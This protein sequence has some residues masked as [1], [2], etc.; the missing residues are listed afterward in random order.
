MSTN[1]E[2]N[3]PTNISSNSSTSAFPV[4][5]I[6]ASAG[7]LEAFT[8]L[9]G[10]LAVD[11][12]M[13]FV[14]IQH[15]NPEQP[16]LLSE[17]LSR[18]TSMTVTEVQN[19]M[20][21]EP[22]CVYVIPSNRKMSIASGVLTLSQRQ[23]NGVKFMPIDSFFSALAEDVGS[24]AIGVVLSGTDGD[25]ALGLKAIKAYGGLAFAQ[26]EASSQFPGMPHSAAAT[27]LVDFIL[28]P[29]AIAAE[30]ARIV[31][32]PYLRPTITQEEIPESEEARLAVVSMLYSATGVD[33]SQYKRPSFRRR[34]QRRMA[35]LQLEQIQEYVSYLEGHP[36][37]VQA[38]YYDVLINVTAF[39]RDPEVFEV[40][41]S[42][43]LP[44]ITAD[45]SLNSPIRIWVPGCATGEE[46]YSLAICLLEFLKEQSLRA[47]VQI[48]GT[49]ISEEAIGLARIGLYHPT[50]LEAVSQE[51]LQRFF[52]LSDGGFQVNK[53]VR[54]L[55]VFARH[56]LLGDPPFSQM[57]LVSCRNVLIYF[58]PL[59]QKRVFTTFHY[60]LKSSGY[61]LLGTSETPVGATDLFNLADTSTKFYTRK[62]VPAR[63]P[64]SFAAGSM[65][66]T[67]SHLKRLS[68][69]DAANDLNLQKEADQI[70]LNRY[71]PPGVVINTDG[72][73][74]HFRGQT[75]SYL[76][77]GPGR[78]SLNVLKMAHPS[79][80]AELRSAFQ[81]VKKL[82][83]SQ[84]REDLQLHEADRE[85]RVRID[86]TPFK[87]ASGETY[88]LVLFTEM[89]LPTLQT[90]RESSAK[91]RN[92]DQQR[93]VE[94]QQELIAKEEYLRTVIEE[95][96]TVNQN[97]RMANEEIL[98]SNEELQSTNEELQT[99]KEEIQ[100]TN[101]ELHTINEELQRR[102]QSLDQLGND[103]QN[104]LASTQ[105]PIV[106]LDGALRIRR[107]TPLAG[108][109]LNLIPTDVGR[110]IG[111]INLQLS[112]SD[113]PKRIQEVIGTLNTHSEEVQD[114]DERWYEMRIRPYRTLDNKIEG[115]A[116][117]LVD[118]DESKRAA[119]TIKA[120]RDY[121]QS[122]VE[123]V[124]V[125]L[126]VLNADLRIVTANR[127]FYELFQTTPSETE[128]QLFFALGNGQ[129]NLP[130]LRQLLENVLP[131]NAQ[132][133]D[134]EVQQQFEKIGDRIIRLNGCEVIGHERGR[135]ILLS[136]EDITEQSRAAELQRSA[137][138]KEYELNELKS[139][140]IAIASHEFRTP[141]STIILSSQLLASDDPNQS[142]EK[143]LA[144]QQRI[145]KAIVQ[146]TNLLDGILNVGRSETEKIQIQR[147]PLEIES[148]CQQLI[149]ELQ[150]TT[151]RLILVSDIQ[152]GYFASLD[153]NM[154]K[155]ILTNLITNA[156]KYSAVDGT[157]RLEVACQETEVIFKIIDQGIGI[158]PED[159]EQLFEPF[160]RG[161]NVGSIPGSGLGLAIVKRLVKMLKGQIS[162]E[163][164]IDHGTT[165]TVA[166]PLDEPADA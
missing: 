5:G 59:A 134:Y 58:A 21:V 158:P 110:P 55:C 81:Q 123:T 140:L 93:I 78:A 60:S 62:L 104:L 79:L 97:L 87:P 34:L 159:L 119:E 64:M 10:A 48:F 31:R 74:L 11:T 76:E 130:P 165:F 51:R 41:K 23:K 65:I 25:G 153:A 132:L 66:S 163:S 116:V 24:M 17:I 14:L 94:L 139:R 145:E 82:S 114:R 115:A 113:L 152:Q 61:L 91:K 146:I 44:A 137:L 46:V 45:K 56:N 95:S 154:L 38:L 155:Q 148:F 120:S 73:I 117:V 80:R 143:R 121:A 89:P 118:I 9:L 96:E 69:G 83:V 57:D 105:I 27:G 141:L 151:H 142:V 36:E 75:G 136:L 40:V 43:V 112:V 161:Q 50:Q 86:I 109:L 101:E 6:G 144:H 37:E 124:R 19:G 35:L 68:D 133:L 131:N 8:Q 103:L 107:F 126:M 4:V 147:V 52:T 138:Q 100:A 33:F 39:F 72:D 92:L 26:D 67:A 98:S 70:V 164:Q 63:L 30:L 85:R 47:T 99:A 108:Q 156:L 128:N 162:L 71:A 88:F 13:A 12:G 106:M 20:A 49:D 150:N 15:L 84:Y 149:E 90:G 29:Q 16:S 102:N 166:L 1:P 32:H 3:I 28:P 135:L 54:E 2:Q 18:T 77:P 125:P 160:Y 127:A 157:V 129:W 42:L 111:D 122:I 22:N 53:E 7:G